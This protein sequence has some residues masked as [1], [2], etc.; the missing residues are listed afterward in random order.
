MLDLQRQFAKW[1]VGA[2]DQVFIAIALDRFPSVVL[3]GRRQLSVRTRDEIYAPSTTNRDKRRPSTGFY[4][5]KPNEHDY[6]Y[7]GADA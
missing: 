7:A 2:R 5:G 4:R 1:A 3:P 6:K